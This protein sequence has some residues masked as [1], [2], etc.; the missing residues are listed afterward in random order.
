MLVPKLWSTLKIRV[1]S[2]L[3]RLKDSL[4]ASYQISLNVEPGIIAQSFEKILK[5]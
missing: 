4:Q 3:Q 5:S 1:V 2:M